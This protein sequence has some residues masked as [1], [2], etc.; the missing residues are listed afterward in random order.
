MKIVHVENHSNGARIAKYPVLVRNVVDLPEYGRMRVVGVLQKVDGAVSQTGLATSAC[1]SF[2]LTPIHSNDLSKCRIY[3][4][5][6]KLGKLAHGKTNSEL[7]DGWEV[8]PSTET[9]TISND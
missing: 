2:C 1:G 3:V 9:F 5:N 7:A 6:F 4:P 8:V